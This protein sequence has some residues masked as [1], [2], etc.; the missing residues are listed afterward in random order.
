MADKTRIQPNAKYLESFPY[1]LG[2]TGAKTRLLTHRATNDATP[3]LTIDD[4]RLYRSCVG[5]LMYYLSD[6]ADAQ[7]EGSILGSSLRA[8]TTG[9]M[10]AMRRVTVYVLGKHDAY[11]KAANPER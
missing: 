7:L 2:L 3:L 1:Q 11:V 9:A 4:T 5:A 6:R 10:E 8:P